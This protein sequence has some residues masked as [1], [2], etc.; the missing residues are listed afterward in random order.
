[1]CIPGN[2]ILAALWHLMCKKKDAQALIFS[3]M[4]LQQTNATQS[5]ATASSLCKLKKLR[6]Y[7]GAP[8]VFSSPFLLLA[9]KAGE[10]ATFGIWPSDDSAE[11]VDVAY[12]DWKRCIPSVTFAGMLATATDGLLGGFGVSWSS[13]FLVPRSASPAVWVDF[14]AVVASRMRHFLSFCFVLK[15]I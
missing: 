8:K 5:F 14:Q 10:P 2:G 7:F 11:H 9:T 3:C 12:Q 6:P 13:T 4:Q 1:M 15:F